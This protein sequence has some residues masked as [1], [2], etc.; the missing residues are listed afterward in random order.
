MSVV[1]GLLLAGNVANA[2][3]SLTACAATEPNGLEF[4]PSYIEV[5]TGSENG[6]AGD[7]MFNYTKRTFKATFFW[8]NADRLR[9][10]NTPADISVPGQA[11]LST[12]YPATAE[13]VRI[14]FDNSNGRAYGKA[15]KTWAAYLP[16]PTYL[17]NT[18]DS[19]GSEKSISIGT[20]RAHL[21]RLYP[22]RYEVWADLYFDPYPDGTIAQGGNVPN[23]FRISSVRGQTSPY[24]C[25]MGRC[26]THC[27]TV[28]FIDV[29]PMS[30]GVKAPERC[31]MMTYGFFD[32]SMVPLARSYYSR[33]TVKSIVTKREERP[34]Q[35]D[36]DILNF[37]GIQAPG[38][39]DDFRR[40]S[41]D[42]C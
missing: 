11:F 10:F 39:H 13:P 9:Y 35:L 38:L 36:K 3:P 40:T 29:L 37:I 24:A 31:V 14:S 30:A 23:T 32:Q 33:P 8:H 27:N 22:I 7:R 34:T 41:A 19:I 20:T 25:S 18:L 15:V 26:V 28:N 4:V 6:D 17:A 2:A 16:S 12:V 42:L 5:I 1:A 21:V